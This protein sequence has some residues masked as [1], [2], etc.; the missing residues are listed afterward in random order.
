MFWNH[1][2]K[3]GSPPVRQSCV[4]I[5]TSSVMHYMNA[6]SKFI[7]NRKDVKERLKNCECQYHLDDNI[8]W[9]NQLN[10][11]MNNFV[12]LTC[13]PKIRHFDLA[14]GCGSTQ[15]IPKLIKPSCVDGTCGRCGVKQFFGTPACLILSTC[16]DTVEKIEWKLAARQGINKKNKKTHSLKYLFLYF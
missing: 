1:R 10:I 5:I 6:L 4:D 7:R 16:P 11:H 12:S 14:I 3:C 9:H 13:C 2:C 8:N 15:K